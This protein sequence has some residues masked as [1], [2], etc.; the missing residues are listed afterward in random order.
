MDALPE[1]SMAIAPENMAPRISEISGNL[2]NPR[3]AIKKNRWQI[4]FILPCLHDFSIQ[5]CLPDAC[6]A[7]KKHMLMVQ[8]TKRCVYLWNSLSATKMELRYINRCT[9]SVR[10]ILSTV[11]TGLVT[12]FFVGLYINCPRGQR[13]PDS[14]KWL[15]Q[16]SSMTQAKPPLSHHETFRGFGWSFTNLLVQWYSYKQCWWEQ[17]RQLGQGRQWVQSNHHT[18]Q[19]H[20]H[21][22]F[23]SMYIKIRPSPTPIRSKTLQS[24]CSPRTLDVF[25]TKHTRVFRVDIDT[26]KNCNIRI[27]SAYHTPIVT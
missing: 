1:A 3:A 7:C 24:S 8:A 5:T 13:I 17:L 22:N 19:N 2:M 20:P 14:S 16:W 25:E 27:I 6:A 23:Y 4:V 9:T 11:S 10:F 21:H 18:C 26:P 15:F 12:Y